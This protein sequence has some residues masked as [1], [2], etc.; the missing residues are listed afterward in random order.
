M[1]RKPLVLFAL[2]ILHPRDDGDFPSSWSSTRQD[3]Q[4]SSVEKNTELRAYTKTKYLIVLTSYIKIWKKAI[5]N[6]FV[7][8]LSSKAYVLS[9]L[10]KSLAMTSLMDDPLPQKSIYNL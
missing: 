3:N 9:F 1:Q 6:I 8:L 2:Q 10:N 5:S 4:S 7:M